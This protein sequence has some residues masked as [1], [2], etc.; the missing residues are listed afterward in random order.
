MSFYNTLKKERKKVIDFPASSRDVNN[1]TLP[2][3]VI[4]LFPARESFVGD[5]P[6]G[7]GNVACW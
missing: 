5:I 1:Q 4:K 7:D 2:G 3:L 6:A